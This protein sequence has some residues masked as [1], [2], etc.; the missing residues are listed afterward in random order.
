[1]FD[2]TNIHLYDKKMGFNE[3]LLIMSALRDEKGCPWDKEQTRESLKPFILEEAHEVLEAIDDGQPNALKEELGDLLFQVVFQAQ[4][5]KERNEFD[6]TD[7]IDAVA[8]KMIARHPHVFGNA[9]YQTS[10][11][12]LVHWESQKKAEGKQKKSIIDGIPGTLPSLLRAQRIQERVSRI[13]FDWKSLDDVMEK[14]EEEL[15]EFRN[16]LNSN[17]KEEIEHELGDILFV[18]VNVSRFIGINPEDALRKTIGTFLSRFQY[19][20]VSA[21]EMGKNLSDMT[22]SEMDELWDEAKQDK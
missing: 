11:E 21:R 9:D 2:K 5:A 22:L 16:A 8:E 15:G 13:G 7:V 14:L 20:E 17:R 18:L 1:L 12:V 4:L 3:L 19:M 10:E 6:M